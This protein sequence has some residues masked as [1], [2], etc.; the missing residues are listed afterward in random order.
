MTSVG[1]LSDT[2]VARLCVFC[3][4][5]VCMSCASEHSVLNN[6]TAAHLD[7]GRENVLVCRQT[8][9]FFLM[10]KQQLES[11]SSLLQIAE[12]SCAVFFRYDT[13]VMDGW[14]DR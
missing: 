11:Q 8:E 9:Q 5:A 7:T 10:S 13:A 2:V 14:T 12:L 4:C 6:C 1:S 3:A